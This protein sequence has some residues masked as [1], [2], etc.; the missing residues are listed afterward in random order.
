MGSPGTPIP[1]H[2]DMVPWGPGLGLP[3]PSQP[4]MVGK[5]SHTGKPAAP[6]SDPGGCSDTPSHPP[7]FWA[8]LGVPWHI[9]GGGL[10]PLS[11]GSQAHLRVLWQVWGDPGHIWK[12]LGHI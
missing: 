1:H 7:L 9:L 8:H 4:V 12:N 11:Q 10:V 6:P 2:G 3:V 5:L